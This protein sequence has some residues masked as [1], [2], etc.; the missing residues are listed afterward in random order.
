MEFCVTHSDP[1]VR[2][3]L[4]GLSSSQDNPQFKDGTVYRQVRPHCIEP[5]TN[6]KIFAN[7]IQCAIGDVTEETLSCL[8][9]F[10][11]ASPAFVALLSSGLQGIEAMPAD[12]FVEV[13]NAGA[14]QYACIE[15][16]P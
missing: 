15:V 13:S 10:A 4:L 6:F 3:N 7:G 1:P 2:T 12:E 16:A 8:Q 11:R 14:Q 9:N 5:E